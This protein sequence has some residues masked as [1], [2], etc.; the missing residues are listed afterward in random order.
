MSAYNANTV[1]DSVFTDF[2]KNRT[3]N[4]RNTSSGSWRDPIGDNEWVGLVKD[5]YVVVRIVS[6]P[7]GGAGVVARPEDVIEVVHAEVKDDNGKYFP[8]IYPVTDGDLDHS[9]IMHRFVAK[10]LEVE[11]S[12]TEKGKK[13]F[14]HLGKCPELVDKVE[15][16]NYSTTDRQRQ[17]SKGFKGQTMMI[18]NVID[19]AD[20]QWHRDNL[21]TKL[22]SKQSVLG[23]DGETRFITMGVP[24][25]GFLKAFGEMLDTFGN[26]SKY[27]VAIK[28][29]GDKTTP[30]VIQ[31]AS[32]KKEK[33]SLDEL[34][35]ADGSFVNGDIISTCDRLT[36]EELS[37]AV[38]NLREQFAPTSFFTLKKRIGKMFTECD[39][40]LGTRFIDELDF[41]I[42][43]E[44]EE[45]AK[46][47][48]DPDEE[49]KDASVTVQGTSLGESTEDKTAKREV[50]REVHRNTIA[51]PVGGQLSAEQLAVLKGYPKLNDEEKAAIKDV[52]L[53]PDGTLDKIV[54]DPASGEQADCPDC[55]TT[56]PMKFTRCPC[57]GVSFV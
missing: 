53:K 4:V 2:V 57:C 36:D 24:T 41:L 32:R 29:T 49:K 42:E 19:R 6:A 5:D 33:D 50:Q 55:N 3:S 56:S 34:K 43:K 40:V 38:V 9:H 25:F 54:Y 11:W 21:K 45:Y 1:D 35:Q 12:K 47:N 44:R 7:P 46:K 20:M 39:N 52:V 26:W 22:L 8:I 37:W 16:G 13:S 28:K 31:N 51:D 23:R 14:K 18:M 17:F 15:H 30:Y 27:D 10:V 48:Q